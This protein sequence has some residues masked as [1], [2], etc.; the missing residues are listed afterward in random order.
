[1]TCY[2]RHLQVV[3]QKAGIKVTKE[4]KRAL[5]KLIHDFVGV[6]YKQCSATWSAVKTRIAEDE[7]N[8]IAMLKDFHLS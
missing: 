3:F 7:E 2:F 5:D 1:M 8:F 6:E 4:N